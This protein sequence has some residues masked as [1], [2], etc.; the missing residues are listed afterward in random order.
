MFYIVCYKELCIGNDHFP[1]K[2]MFKKNSLQCIC[3]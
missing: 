3:V 2:Y 1:I